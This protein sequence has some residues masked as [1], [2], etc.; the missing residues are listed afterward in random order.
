MRILDDFNTK[1]EERN[2][3]GGK[4]CQK[5]RKGALCG[6]I[7]EIKFSLKHFILNMIMNLNVLCAKYLEN[8]M[9]L[10]TCP[11][12]Y[13]VEM[14]VATLFVLEGAMT[15]ISIDAKNFHFS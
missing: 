10:M 5:Y 12:I 4:F 13:R 7:V 3:R 15:E 6:D 11:S 2:F 9:L 8:K 1:L 14:L